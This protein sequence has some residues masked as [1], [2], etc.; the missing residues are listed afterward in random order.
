MAGHKFNPERAGHLEGRL[1]RFL[2][3]PPRILEDLA[4][5]PEEEWAEIGAGTGYFVIPLS[6]LVKKIHALD[7][8][9][10]MLAH[11]RNN[12][13]QS[14]VTN[15][16][17]QR[18]EESRFPLPDT[19]VDAVLLAMVLHEVDKPPEFI[20]EA[21]RVTRPGGRLLVIEY[22]RTGIFG[23]P[24]SHRLTESQ[25]DEWTAAAGYERSRSWLW[26]KRVAGWQYFESVGLEY[27]KQP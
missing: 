1:R 5:Q 9:D 2:M 15:V 3:P 12:L 14:G 26:G 13:Q 16:E 10:E 11:L 24:K 4:P 22:T 20:A 19:G 18:S 8:S 7:L 25:I 6:R 23:P 27:R 21:A 17:A